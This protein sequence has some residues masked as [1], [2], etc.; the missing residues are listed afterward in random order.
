MQFDKKAEKRFSYSNF[1]YAL[2]GYIM[3]KV[4]HKTYKT[5]LHEYVIK[6]HGLTNTYV[7]EKD[8]PKDL[9][10]MPYAT[11]K[12]EIELLPWITG[13]T[14][15][16]GGI[17]SSA[18]DLLKIMEAQSKA[19]KGY[20]E[21]KE[22]SPMLLTL[23][24]EKVSG[25]L[26]YG[27]GMF[28]STKGFNEQNILA[29]G[30]GGDLDGYGS[31]YD[32]YPNQDLGLIML[33]SS[34]GKEFIDFHD[35]LE[36]SLLGLPEKKEV[37][38]SGQKLKRYEGTYQ[39]ESGQQIKIKRKGERLFTSGKGIPSLQLHAISE[40]S[41]FYKELDG[42]FKF[43]FG[44]NGKISSSSYTQYGEISQLQKIK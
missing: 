38:L 44:A 21:T 30:H 15:A 4:S 7:V 23:K 24:K 37:F 42:W 1:G 28:E 17:F 22:F 40:V 5:L 41:F 39:F 43:E 19:L 13:T 25:A 9:L 11:H 2:L 10:A 8:V 32:L 3:Q 35:Q 27:F 20:K 34:G 6:P 18:K 16:S 14:I 36:R 12:R 31:F 26:Y 29:L 33:T